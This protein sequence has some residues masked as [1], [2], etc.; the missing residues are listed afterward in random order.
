M[1]A[2]VQS[3]HTNSDSDCSGAV[4]W[5]LK[6]AVGFLAGDQEEQGGEFPIAAITVAM[7]ATVLT[8]FFCFFGLAR[9]MQQP[10][11]YEGIL[12]PLRM[13]LFFLFASTDNV[14]E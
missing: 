6:R 1:F 11:I 5:L 2:L 7:F 14:A 3:R 12:A 10:Q 9:I 8:H 4:D 13:P